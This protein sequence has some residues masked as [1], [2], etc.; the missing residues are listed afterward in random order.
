ML[1]DINENNVTRTVIAELAETLKNLSPSDMV[2]AVELINS[3]S[4]L[5]LAGAGR[6]ALAVRGFAMRLMHLGKN[7]YLVGET[8]TPGIAEGDL[9]LIGS[10][11]GR[12]G[13]LL[14]MAE[15]ANKIGA[16]IL[17]ITIDPQSPIARLAD[18]VIEFPTPSPKLTGGPTKGQ[19]VQ[20]MGSLFEQ[21]L[22]IFLDSLV[23]LLM[24]TNNLTSAEMF[25]RHANLE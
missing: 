16:K 3:S 20:P 6:S 2:N 15:K 4:S 5:F 24:K 21:S 22:F 10:G 23:L 9:L 12:T 13:T 14:S 25:R 1:S 7:S 19:S 17:L 18:L 8:T 11:S